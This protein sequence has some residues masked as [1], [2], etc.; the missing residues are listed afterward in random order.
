MTKGMFDW[1]HLEK[2]IRLDIVGFRPARHDGMR[3][4]KEGD[5]IHAYG[6]GRLRYLYAFSVAEQVKL[7]ATGGKIPAKL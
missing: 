7:L 6:V 4:E 1:I 3:L 2:D 5:N